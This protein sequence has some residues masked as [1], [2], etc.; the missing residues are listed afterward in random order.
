MVR[1]RV[2]VRVRFSTEKNGLLGIQ[3]STF[4]LYV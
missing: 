1:V 2:R 4:K 3:Y